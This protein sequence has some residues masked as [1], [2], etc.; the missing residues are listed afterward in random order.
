MQI[1]PHYFRTA[2]FALLLTFSLA[3]IAPAQSP[4]PGTPAKPP[5][6]TFYSLLIKGGPT[7]IPLGL[8]SIFA[9]AVA[10]DRLLGLRRRRIV[11]RGFMAGLKKVYP[12]SFALTQP[13]I[14]Y[15]ERS[16][17][18]VGR[19]FRAGLINMPR[20][21]AYVEKAL[22]DTGGNELD[23]MKRS[24]HWLGAIASIAPLLGLLGTVIGMMEAFAATSL[25]VGS[26]SEMLAR[27][28]YVAL[29]TTA[30]GLSIAIPVV[31]LYQYLT[32]KV[33]GMVD[34]INE[35]GSEFLEFYVSKRQP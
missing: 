16:K 27:G 7:M 28:I 34:E 30:A 5:P 11:P 31:V 6:E 29:I 33:D 3:G 24:L 22:E 4:A 18:P 2:F 15:C 25:V 17:T 14:E 21:E 19:I 23:K 26:K 9:V 13:A 12:S 32:A 1:L 20:G 8:C 10:F 35:L